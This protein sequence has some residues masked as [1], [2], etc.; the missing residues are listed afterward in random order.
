MVGRK[1]ISYT[2][3]VILLCVAISGCVTDGD[4]Y[5]YGAICTVYLENLPQ[6]YDLLPGPLRENIEI[7]VTLRNISSDR[8]YK[9]RLTESTD[10]R[11]EQALLPGIYSINTYVSQYPRNLFN[12]ENTFDL[13][14]IEAHT[15]TSLP[16]IITN[17]SEFSSTVKEN[18]PGEAI[19]NMDM[20]SGCVQLDGQVVNIREIQAFLL[21]GD[22]TYNT[23]RPLETRLLQSTSHPDVT[24]IM[25]NQTHDSIPTEQATLTGVQFSGINA[26]LPQGVGVGMSFSDIAHAESGVYKTPSYILGTPFIGI[27]YDTA[28]LV[29]LDYR[30]GD[31]ISVFVDANDSFA[32]HITYEFA[33]YE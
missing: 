7:I 22:T 17:A 19:L 21:F 8:D 32:R 12:V 13:L 15:Q 10:F 4:T 26:V 11:Y 14:T 27:G 9:F 31:R 1:K 6:E 25:Q 30:S 24:L 28:T 3:A 23:L 2:L 20:F 16:L 33:K 5:R 29:F 18:Q